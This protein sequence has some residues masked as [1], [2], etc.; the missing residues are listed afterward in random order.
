M[1]WI[2][3]NDAT[4]GSAAASSSKIRTASSRRNPLPPTSS[5]Q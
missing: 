2:E 4:V 5:E 1:L 3:M